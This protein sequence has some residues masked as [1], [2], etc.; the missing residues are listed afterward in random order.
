M[1]TSASKWLL[2]IHNQINK[3]IF[4]KIGR[5]WREDGIS[6]KILE[7]LASS[8]PLV[9]VEGP[10]G[11]QKIA[12]DAYKLSGKPERSA[13]D[14]AVLVKFSY[15]NGNEKEGVAFLEAKRIYP[16]SGEFEQLSTQQLTHHLSFTHAH[17]T[18]L[19]DHQS[20][21]GHYINL[22]SQYYCAACHTEDFR[23]N[24]A[25]TLPTEQAISLDEKTR[26]LLNYSLPL[27]YILITRYLKGFELDYSSSAVKMA[28][29]FLDENERGGVKFLLV[30]HV[31]FDAKLEPNPK[32]ILINKN[33][34]SIIKPGQRR[35]DLNPDYD[36]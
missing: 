29:G 28:K 8:F 19:Y 32:Q 6:E 36:M 24:Y 25:S 20:T 21:E 33:H 12:W 26:N 18:L 3:S 14:I 15:P 10:L 31:S 22:E 9:E 30:A 5:N 2:N 27:S 11:V 4:A 35:N 17:R 1:K 23:E 34:Y 16:K 13:G 7:D